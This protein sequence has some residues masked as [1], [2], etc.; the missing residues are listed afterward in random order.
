MNSYVK[1]LGYIT[2]TITVGHVWRIGRV[3]A[4]RPKGHGFDSHSSRHVETLGKFFTHSCLWRFGVKFRHV[5][6]RERLRVVADLKRRYRN[7]LNECLKF[8]RIF[9]LACQMLALFPV[10]L[11]MLIYSG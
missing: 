5:L 7:T 10:Y 8:A 6:C 4:Y 2:F 11:K 9:I 3:D 1:T